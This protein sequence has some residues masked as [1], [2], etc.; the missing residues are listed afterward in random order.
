MRVIA[1]VNQK[2]GVGK[3]TSVVNIASKLAMLG[4]K[5]LVIDLDPQGNLSISLGIPSHEL[6]FT[7]YEV[8]K[9]VVTIEE[10]VFKKDK[11]HVLPANI[12][13]SGAEVE[14][15]RA[16]GREFLLR[17]ALEKLDKDA[18]DYVL[19]DCSPSLGILTLNA[20]VACREVF[21]PLQAEYLAMQGINQLINTISIVKSRLNKKIEI[22]G[23]IVTMYDK[24]KN[25]HK[26]VVERIKEHFEDKV[27]KTYINSTVAL[28]EAPSFGK[29]IFEY[30]ADSIGAEDYESLV[31]EII[32][33]PQPE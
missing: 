29:D 24:R 10:A 32:K 12:D 26:E 18:Y 25:L 7:V 8:L 13:L 30:K 33:M 11:F 9:E 27:F 4:K 21:I 17:E 22:T 31:K 1:V 28:A 15:S 16:A 6:E 14:L 23:I 5:V 2:G 19:I 20:L 3:T